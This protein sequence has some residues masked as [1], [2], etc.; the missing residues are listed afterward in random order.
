MK[1]QQTYII[2]IIILTQSVLNLPIDVKQLIADVAGI[3]FRRLSV[4]CLVVMQVIES[5]KMAYYLQFKQTHQNLEICLI[6]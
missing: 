6:V 1:R 3:G 4:Q 5:E 2:I